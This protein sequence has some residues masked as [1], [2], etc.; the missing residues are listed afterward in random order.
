MNSFVQKTDKLWN[1]RKAYID[2]AISFI[3]FRSKWNDEL[4]YLAFTAIK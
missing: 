4:F 3:K 2:L 1:R